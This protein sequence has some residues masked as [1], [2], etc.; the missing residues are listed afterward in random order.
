MK[1][2][3]K[4]NLTEERILMPCVICG[5]LFWHDSFYRKSSSS[6]NKVRKTCSLICCNILKK[7]TRY[8]EGY[9]SF[10]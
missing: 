1:E 4:K 8:S 7:K 10:K 9:S 3:P 5:T 2:T 6:Q